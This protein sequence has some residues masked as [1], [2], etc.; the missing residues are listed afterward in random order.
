MTDILI[1]KCYHRYRKAAAETRGK[2][3]A[4]STKDSHRATRHYGSKRGKG[5]LPKSLYREHAALLT[6]W[7]RA[8]VSRCVRE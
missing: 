7:L 2:P 6:T 8:L 1:G 5:V 3:E 4:C